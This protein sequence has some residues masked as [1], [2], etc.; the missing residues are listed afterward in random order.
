MFKEEE[1]MPAA[2]DGLKECTKCG[3]TKPVSEYHKHKSHADGL[4]YVCRS[5][6]KKRYRS[7][8]EQILK[9]KKEYYEANKEKKLEHQKE[10]YKK[11]PAAVY[12]IENTITGKI[13]IG[14]SKSYPARWNE[15]KSDMRHEGHP[16]LQHDYDKHGLDSFEFSVIKEYPS[17]T[18]R[19]IL[20]EHEQRLIDEYIAEG[21]DL[22][23]I[24]RNH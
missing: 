14:Q 13:Y 22:Y 19:E 17:D 15:H 4:Q 20:F 9:S 3:E 8:K 24:D 7:D 6:E 1:L 16:C 12:K 10:Y 21:K 2:V 18:S 11:L 23:N 5:C